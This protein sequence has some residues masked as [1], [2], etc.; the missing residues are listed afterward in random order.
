MPLIQARPV[1]T[2]GM[3][4]KLSV[5][6]SNAVSSSASRCQPPCTLAPQMVP[7]ENHGRRS[8]PSASRLASRHPIPVG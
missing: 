8:R 4:R 1:V 6:S 2:S 7:P 5:P 3:P